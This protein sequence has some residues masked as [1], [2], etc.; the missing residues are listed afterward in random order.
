[1]DANQR[2]ETSSYG[3][4]KTLRRNVKKAL[5]HF[6]IQYITTRETCSRNYEWSLD[7]FV[8]TH[9]KRGI[10]PHIKGEYTTNGTLTLRNECIHTWQN[11]PQLY[12][13]NSKTGMILVRIDHYFKRFT[14]AQNYIYISSLEKPVG[15]ESHL[16]AT[17]ILSERERIQTDVLHHSTDA[18]HQFLPSILALLNN[19][20]KS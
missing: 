20:P 4:V 17:V 18:R 3:T 9:F 1:M 2:L 13:T 7:R 15:I 16:L 8:Y 11:I 12:G 10:Y 5:T 19:G 6:T 14:E